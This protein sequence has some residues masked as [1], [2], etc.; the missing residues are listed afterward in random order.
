[1]MR[2]SRTTYTQRHRTLD[3][4]H[5]KSLD[6]QRLDRI[7][8]LDRYILCESIDL[9]STGLVITSKKAAPKH[10]QKGFEKS[11]LWQIRQRRKK[12]SYAKTPILVHTN[13]YI[14]QSHIP[15]ASH[16]ASQ[17]P[18]PRAAFQK[19]NNNSTSQQTSSMMTTAHTS[20][21]KLSKTH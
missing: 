14:K 8:F 18:K 19:L 11:H 7:C 2:C 10:S 4:S 15:S 3:V 12:A 5:V 21:D 1:M 13:M 20:Q 16:W 17:Q 9:N 6:L